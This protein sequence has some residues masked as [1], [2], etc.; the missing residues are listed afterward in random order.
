M[1]GNDPT[2]LDATGE[3]SSRAVAIGI[4]SPQH[5]AQR[6]EE[7]GAQDDGDSALADNAASMVPLTCSSLHYSAMNGITYQIERGTLKTGYF[8]PVIQS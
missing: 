1:F 2:S 7:L 4:L 6:S 5:L 3:Q 8:Y